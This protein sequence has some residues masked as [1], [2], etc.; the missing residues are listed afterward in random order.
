MDFVDD[1]P[2]EPREHA[3]RILVAGQQRKA[4]GRGQQNMGRVGALAALARGRCVA[5]AILDADG[6]G[7]L[8]NRAFQIPADVTGER[9]ER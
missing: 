5:G 7:H 2:L 3:R 1:H 6:Q 9:L 4:F 8:G